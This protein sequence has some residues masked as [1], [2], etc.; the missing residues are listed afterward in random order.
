MNTIVPSSEEMGPNFLRQQVGNCAYKLLLLEGVQ[1]H[2]AFHMSQLKKHV[3]SSVVPIP[4]LPLVTA[5]MKI[6]TEPQAVLQTR[7]IPCNNVAVI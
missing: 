3:G 4:Y 7:L 5:D 1:I 6:Q 2:P